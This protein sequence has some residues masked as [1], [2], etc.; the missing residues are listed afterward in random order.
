MWQTATLHVPTLIIPGDTEINELKATH[1][2]QQ[3]TTILSHFVAVCT[4]RIVCYNHIK[5]QPIFSSLFI[6]FFFLSIL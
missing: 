6:S 2:R 1:R 3:L 4:I 5:I